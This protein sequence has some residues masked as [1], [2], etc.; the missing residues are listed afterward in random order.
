MIRTRYRKN[1]Q[2][3]Y[4]IQPT[5]WQK[6]LVVLVDRPCREYIRLMAATSAPGLGLS[7]PHLHRDWAHPSHI[8]TGTGLAPP[9]SAPGPRWEWQLQ[10]RT[11][12]KTADF[13]T[14]AAE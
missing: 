8:C 10:A 7:R 5:K 6:V 14:R 2:A 1:I 9:T 3:L 12:E 4:I 13:S 11:F